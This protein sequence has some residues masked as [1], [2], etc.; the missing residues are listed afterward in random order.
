MLNLEWFRTFKVVYESGTLSAAAEVL[1]I[2]QPGVSLHLNSLESYTGFR[3]F[4][5]DSRKVLP[6]DKGKL[7]YNYIVGALLNL[8]ELEQR[9]H[10]KSKTG[11]P[12]LSVGMC[13]T[14]FQHVLESQICNL[15]FNLISRYGEAAKML[16]ELGNGTLDLVISPNDNPRQ[17]LLFRAFSNERIVLICGGKTDTT[18]L[19]SLLLAGNR[20]AIKKWLR[21]QRWFATSANMEYLKSFW[22]MNFKELPDFNPDYILPHFG[23]I[24]RCLDN[25]SGFAV[26]PDYLYREAVKTRS[27][28]LA[29]EGFIPTEN[30]LYFATRR[31]GVHPKEIDFLENLLVSHW[32]ETR[33]M[34]TE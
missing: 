1:F 14:T 18:H 33:S 5:R 10:K 11:R 16:E 12:T 7:M 13:Y 6:T 32:F 25:D 20:S 28:K 21:K 31:K 15:P 34:I 8:E 17:N 4:E 26:V 29:W 27:V 19:E 24:L 22:L 9:L 2:S 30:T 3:L 23:S